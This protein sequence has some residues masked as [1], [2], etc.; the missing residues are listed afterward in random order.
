MK[1]QGKR[2][3]PKTEQSAELERIGTVSA[4]GH[5]RAPADIETRVRLPVFRPMVIH[6]CPLYGPLSGQSG[7]RE[8]PSKDRV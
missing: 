7:I 2:K 6:R 1:I 5:D 8:R 3:R 4:P